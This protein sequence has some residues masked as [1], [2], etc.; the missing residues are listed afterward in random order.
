MKVYDCFIFYNELEL[1]DLRLKELSPFVDYFVICESNKTFSGKD[2]KSVYL[3]NAHLFEEYH[4][5]IIHINYVDD[6]VTDPWER[7]ANQRNAI[8]KAY[9]DADDDDVIMLSDCDELPWLHE[10][11]TFKGDMG[12]F[13]PSRFC[14]YYVNV[15]L[16]KGHGNTQWW[17]KKFN[18]R[19]QAMRELVMW[20]TNAVEG[21]VWV[22][23]AAPTQWA[24]PF[25][26]EGELCE[27]WH[28][29]YLGGADRIRDKI[30][31][32]SHQEY[33]NPEVLD[34]LEHRLETNT[35]IFQD[36]GRQQ[37]LKVI[38]L[39]DHL[40]PREMDWWLKKYPYLLKPT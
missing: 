17:R 23:G 39:E 21:R 37:E 29:S 27:G 31:A 9:E 4:D 6:S 22:E 33:N 34:Q 11:F 25:S 20:H 7:E 18:V 3:E 40:Q 26:H 2:K 14:Y 24:F 13:A 28:F 15:T 8:E 1:L 16:E 38:S 36:C 32:F 19:P 10:T 12:Q 5:K 30:G 35:N